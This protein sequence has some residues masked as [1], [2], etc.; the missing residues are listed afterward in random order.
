MSGQ[1][2]VGFGT[3]VGPEIGTGTLI[4]IDNI[5]GGSG[6]DTIIGD[7]AAN[8]FEGGAGNDILDG[9]IGDDALEGGAGDNFIAGGDGFDT[10]SYREAPYEFDPDRPSRLLRR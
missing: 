10:L 9:G 6:D 8:R 4:E 3:A 7:S 1:D 2:T 5:I